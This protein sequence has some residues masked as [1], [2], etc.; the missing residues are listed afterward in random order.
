MRIA[1]EILIRLYQWTVSPLLGPTCRFEPSCS[2][3]ALEAIRR[4][5]VARGG[6]LAVKRIG[7]CHPWHA[8]GYDP[9][10]DRELRAPC[11]RHP[12]TRTCPVAEDPELKI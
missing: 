11:L 2:Q 6:W 9:V 10:P 3:Y 1:A 7:R 12:G 4:F 5:G 8:G